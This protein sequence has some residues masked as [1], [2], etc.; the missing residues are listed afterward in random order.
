MKYQPGVVEARGS[1]GGSV[2]MTTKRETSGE[3]AKIVLQPD[4]PQINA[5]GEDIAMVTVEV[6][7]A[8]GRYM[9]T[10]S[11]EI[12]F[13]ISGPG[14]LIGVGNGNPSSHESDKADHRK[15][16]NG[17]AQAIVKSLKE[18]GTITVQATSPGLASAT[19]TIA[20]RAATPRPAV[21]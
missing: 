1:K 10:A 13:Q 15:V 18:P 2:V 16:F 3:P 4:R 7:D 19:L 8:Q 12:A 17:W 11:N 14:W 6:Q 5:D 20:A 9:P 21:S